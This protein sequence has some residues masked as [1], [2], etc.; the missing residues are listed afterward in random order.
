MDN[1]KIIFCVFICYC[2]H[3]LSCLKNKLIYYITVYK[4]NICL[5]YQ[6]TKIK[7]PVR[8]HSL[9]E[10]QWGIYF[11]PFWGSCK[12]SAFLAL[13]PSSSICKASKGMLSL[14][15][16]AFIPKRSS[17]P[18]PTSMDICGNTGPFLYSRTTSLT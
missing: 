9:L 7:V 8:L 6:W 12:L 17:V 4:S 15:S 10:F 18:S 2:Y 5:R 14:F 3:K 11:F 1:F 16:Q 13:W